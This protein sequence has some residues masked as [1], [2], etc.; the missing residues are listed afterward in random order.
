MSMDEL[1]QDGEAE[2]GERHPRDEQQHAERHEADGDEKDRP[3]DLGHSVLDAVGSPGEDERFADRDQPAFLA[4]DCMDVAVA[5]S[6][7]GLG[8]LAVEIQEPLRCREDAR[9]RGESNDFMPE[10]RV[11]VRDPDPPI[12]ISLLGRPVGH[13]ERDR[14]LRAR[15]GA[16]NSAQGNPEL[17]VLVLNIRHGGQPNQFGTGALGALLAFHH[18]GGRI[19][20]E[21]HR[22]LSEVVDLVEVEP[23]PASEPARPVRRLFALDPDACITHDQVGIP[24]EGRSPSAVG[25]K[26]LKRRSSCLR[27]QVLEQVDAP[28][29]GGSSKRQLDLEQ[30]DAQRLALEV[31]DL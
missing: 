19:H 1:D 23:Q 5:I 16:E 15:S 26:A 13:P 30:R 28:T 8:C 6:L 22:G 14:P 25:D 18:A 2:V 10:R 4:P 20:L 7:H 12:E 11:V 17:A 9:V 29:H 21:L 24:G 31:A 3:P 27:K